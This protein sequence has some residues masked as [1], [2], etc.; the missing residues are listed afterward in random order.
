MSPTP[1]PILNI[2]YQQVLQ[3]SVR[4]DQENI[5]VCVHD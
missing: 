5:S 2:K 3:S 4:F 1:T